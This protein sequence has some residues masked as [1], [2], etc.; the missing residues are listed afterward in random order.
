MVFGLV[1]EFATLPHPIVPIQ[2]AFGLMIVAGGM[3]CG[4]AVLAR[5]FPKA[6]RFPIIAVALIMFYWQTAAHTSAMPMCL[7]LSIYHFV[8]VVLQV[9]EFEGD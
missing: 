1:S 9:A 7:A 5:Y 3:G 2:D 6:G 4:V 8:S